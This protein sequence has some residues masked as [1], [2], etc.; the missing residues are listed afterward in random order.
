MA[1]SKRAPPLELAPEAMFDHFVDL[2]GRLIKHG[3]ASAAY[4]LLAASLECAK[5]LRS[6][7]RLEQ[8]E[9]VAGQFQA[10]L[11]SASPTH[12]LSG[13]A[14]KQRG[15]PALFISLAHMARAARVGVKRQAAIEGG[16]EWR[17]QA[18]E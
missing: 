11:D 9:R 13:A 2:S 15:M 5:Q 18:S 14:A 12:E 10:Q 16:S 7:E 6:E 8:V 17:Q 4:H 1:D 3:N